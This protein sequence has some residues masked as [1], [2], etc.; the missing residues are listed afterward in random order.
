MAEAFAKT[1][2]RDYVY[3]TDLPDAQTVMQKLQD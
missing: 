1:T 3:L 2:K